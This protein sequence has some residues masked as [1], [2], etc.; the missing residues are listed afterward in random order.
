MDQPTNATGCSNPNGNSAALAQGLPSITKNS[1]QTTALPSFKQHPLS[2]AFPPMQADEYQALFDSIVEIGM[3]N[4]ITIYEGQVLDGW[5][6]YTVVLDCGMDCPTVELGD[7]DP[8]DFVKSQNLHRRHL[9]GSQRAAAVVACSTWHSAHREKKSVPG[10]D[11]SKTDEQ[12]AKEAG[13][14]VSTVGHAKAAQKAGLLEPVRDGAL[15]AKEAAIVARCTPPKPATPAKKAA[16]VPPDVN[17]DDELAEASE[18]IT[19]LS[20]EVEELKAQI[21]VGNMDATGEEKSQAAV[22][23]AE[24]R[25]E[26]KT[27][28]AELSAMRVSRDMLQ[29]EN[30]ELMKQCAMQ[31]KLLDKAAT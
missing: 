27:L 11:L 1:S 15:T 26:V 6:R 19:A 16:F 22:I 28:N 13:V 21:A 18:T 31:R 10:T 3:Q 20:D 25:A 4:P 17:H 9:T 14:S 24:L 12:M 29:S 30:R 23:I 7:I 8:V 2:A 5:N